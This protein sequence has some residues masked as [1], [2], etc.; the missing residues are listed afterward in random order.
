[1]CGVS[2][3]RR[4]LF[5]TYSYPG[6]PGPSRIISGNK[7][8]I[9][10]LF[11]GTKLT[12]MK[13]RILL[14]FI[15]L[16]AVLLPQ[17]AIAYDFSAVSPSG[18]TLWYSIYYS[19]TTVSVVP[20]FTSSPYYTTK[21]IGDVI[22]PE[23]VEF[24]G[25]SYTVERIGEYAFY[26]CSGITSI[27]LPS[28]ILS[29][30]QYAFY[31]CKGLSVINI[32]DGITS[33]GYSSLY[34]CDK[35]TS[36][37]IPHAVTYISNDAFRSCNNL[38]TVFFNADSCSDSYSSSSPFYGSDIKIVYVGNNVKSIPNS[39]FNGIT[40]LRE[41]YLGDSV[42]R[43]GDNAFNGCNKLHSI[44]IPSS[45]TFIG[46]NAFAYCYSL[47]T[48]TIPPTIVDIGA[49]SF[50]HVKMIYNNTSIAGAPWGALSMN[51]YIEDSLYYTDSN[52]DTLVGA[53]AELTTANIPASV[54][55]IG[56]YAFAYCERISDLSIPQTV[57][58]IGAFAFYGTTNMK[59]FHFNADSCIT[60]S[61]Y[62]TSSGTSFSNNVWGIAPYRR[63]I[64]RCTIGNS[65]KII[66]DFIFYNFGND[67]VIIPNSV[68]V[69]GHSAFMQCRKLK[70]VSFGGS[71]ASIG[72]DAFYYT[73][74]LITTNYTGTIAQ[75]CDISFEDNYANPIYY[76]H[77][78][79]INDSTVANLVIP[80]GVP[81]IKQYAFCHCSSLISAVIPAS[82]TSIGK[83][84]FDGCYGI[85]KVIV[86][87]GVT[88]IG[89]YA[90]DCGSY[91]NDLFFVSATPPYA[92][93]IFS[94]YNNTFYGTI[95]IPCGTTAVYQDSL[96]SDKNYSEWTGYILTATAN[97]TQYGRV[98]Q[99]GNTC[100]TPEATLTATPIRQHRFVQWDDGNTDNPRTVQV[101]QDTT[102]TAIFDT[103]VYY[104]V[105]V[106]ADSSLH[107]YCHGGGTFEAFKQYSVS[108]TQNYGYHFTQWS[109]GDTNNPRYFSLTQDTAF[110]AYFERNEYTL[111]FQSSDTA[112]GI[113]DIAS[114]TGLYLDSTSFITA[115][116]LP[117]YHF[118]RWNDGSTENPRRFIFNSNT[119]Y[120]ALF[121]ID[122]HTVDVHVDS[123][124]HGTVDGGG[125][126]AYGSAAVVSATAYSGYQFTHWSD[127]A[128]FNPYT[129][130]VLED[131]T[132][133][134]VFVAN[135]EPWQDTVFF[136]DTI[137]VHD[138]VALI[139]YDTL[140]LTDTLLMTFYDT[141]TLY[142]TIYDTIYITE[143]GIDGVEAFNIKVYA[144]HGQI[145]VDGA[146]GYSTE[147]Y[148]ITGRLVEHVDAPHPSPL[149]IHVAPGI[150]LVKIG[151]F[152]ARKVVAIRK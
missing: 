64:P 141:V 128:T 133:T 20:Q 152:P 42:N 46:N 52:K 104:N 87:S 123:L 6:F 39:I 75:W 108:A 115:T 21:P 93:N 137:I 7:R 150:Y 138:T 79:S 111:T 125:N 98:T 1:M 36:I 18:H 116:P 19:G 45:V 13:H 84:A 10:R 144:S 12:N 91:L 85:T 15:L 113:V 69:I 99:S 62:P 25:V 58:R 148:D 57:S 109:D 127:G 40:Y 67:S 102:F 110:T 121:A 66:P 90:F 23:T 70:Y 78:L 41:V 112:K 26:N 27:S 107:G 61:N 38:D 43:I 2:R 103:I 51:G 94:S 59:W 139:S 82:V 142:D 140:R 63:W 8:I 100:Q 117:H 122:I 83:S 145:V 72:H 32:P 135:G 29:I 86:G 147:L 17:T 4:E 101:T 131:K 134:A 24:N 11:H 129:F 151:D 76:S 95:H 34:D 81:E 71:I 136:Y 54:K 130:A 60:G 16:M 31:G 28:T 80:D 56:P 146:E 68:T 77:A 74:S 35:I 106:Q 44:T 97:N 22:V 149:T 55:T 37:T 3:A 5:N 73:D 114:L 105:T 65:V 143:Q 132:L 30:E 119:C 124:A 120:T 49:T 96:G 48:V 53:D 14:F 33:I 92:N 88:S 47:D 126:F 118:V 50:L 9:Q 89:R